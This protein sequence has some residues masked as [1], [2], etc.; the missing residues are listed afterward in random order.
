MA[1]LTEQQA[2]QVQILPLQWG[3]EGRYSVEGRWL[4]KTYVYVIQNVWTQ[5]Y[6][7]IWGLLEARLPYASVT[8]H[9]GSEAGAEEAAG[10]LGLEIVDSTTL[11]HSKT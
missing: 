10:M 8:C 4:E 9:F 1:Y 2:K 6:L 11:K 7:A 3:G 5:R